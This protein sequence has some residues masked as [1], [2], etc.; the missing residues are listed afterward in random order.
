VSSTK[1]YL[2]R[3][4]ST[5]WNE[6]PRFRGLA[7]LALS[8]KGIAQAQAL[9]DLLADRP[10]AAVYTSSLRRAVQTAQ[11]IAEPK[12]LALKLCE[13]LRSVD[14]GRWEGLTEEEAERDSPPLYRDYI[15]RIETVR[16]PGGE[17]LDELR[18]RAMAVI[19]EICEKHPSQEV[20][21]VSHQVVTRVLLCSFLGVSSAPY[22]RIG[23]DAGCLNVI[24]HKAGRFEVLSMNV[25]PSRAFA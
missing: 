6:S 1:I 13:G 25:V 17:T 20:V 14:Y 10:Y 16:F 8:E 22:W 18:V 11:I 9:R 4:G 15:D 19:D 5:A 12:G 2:A 7:D 23:Q 24:K 21:V 3:H